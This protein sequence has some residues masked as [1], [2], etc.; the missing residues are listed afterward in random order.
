[1]FTTTVDNGNFIRVI[2]KILKQSSSDAVFHKINK[3]IS[4]AE[5]KVLRLIFE[6]L[7]NRLIA[8]QLNLALRTIEDH[9][10]II[11]RTL[12]VDNVVDLVKTAAKM[13]LDDSE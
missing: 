13:D 4:P 6:G 7:S 3:P 12:G 9:R 8:E 2:K 1:M 10:S 11:M 5:K